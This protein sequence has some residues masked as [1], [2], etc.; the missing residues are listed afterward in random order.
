MRKKF[1]NF[2]VITLTFLMFFTSVISAEKVQ[3]DRNGKYYQPFARKIQR[4]YLVNVP[5]NEELDNIHRLPDLW[6]WHD[7]DDTN[8]NPN[9]VFN[10]AT[11]REDEFNP[12]FCLDKTTH[13]GY[14]NRIFTSPQELIDDLFAVSNKEKEVRY[15]M[16]NAIKIMSDTFGKTIDP[17]KS[18]QI[19]GTDE[20]SINYRVFRTGFQLAMWNLMQ[21]ITTY[22][23]ADLENGIYDVLNPFAPG[24]LTGQEALDEI[25]VLKKIEIFYNAL[26]A[27]SLNAKEIEPEFTVNIDDSS[28]SIHNPGGS[29][30]FYGPLKVVQDQSHKTEEAMLVVSN[31]DVEVV[32]AT[33]S[34]LPEKLLYGSA[35]INKPYVYLN[36]EFYLKIPNSIPKDGIRDVK[37][38]TYVRAVDVICSVPVIFGG[39][40]SDTYQGDPL[41]DIA[42]GDMHWKAAQMT[43]GMFDDVVDLYADDDLSIAS[44][45]FSGQKFIE[46]ND[47]IATVANM[48]TFSV[49][50][51]KGNVVAT[52]TNDI[53]GIISF[54]SIIF[55]KAGTYTFTV[56]EDAITQGDWKKDYTQYTITINVQEDSSKELFVSGYELP[57]AITFR[58]SRIPKTGINDL[59][60]L[61]FGT[62]LLSYCVFIAIETNKRR[63]IVR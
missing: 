40:Y 59:S 5:D 60:Y 21:N 20:D 45:T 26:I 24:I 3:N 51:S 7:K 50:D 58:N 55:N 19:D 39:E 48:F 52:G 11:W 13:I 32:D 33:F 57:E 6:T 63:A 62:L 9:T 36:D 14:G 29:H 27:E 56:T 53:D 42:H 49:T 37:V 16:K 8:I 34:S 17:Y 54:S 38:T 15:L 44:F 12:I 28:A 25:E 23:V 10:E 1:A 41:G 61:G 4:V 43:I 47:Q 30:Y 22:K 2:V 18:V 35:T 46:N 31:A